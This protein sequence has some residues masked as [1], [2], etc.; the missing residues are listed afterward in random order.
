MKRL[1]LI[2]GSTWLSTVEYYSQINRLA[3]IAVGGSEFPE[4]ILYSVNFGEL[5]RNVAG[6]RMDLNIQLTVDR[7]RDIKAAGAEAVVLCANT[8]HLAAER[9]EA[10]VGLPVIHVA[11]ATAS[12][13]EAAGLNKVGLLGTRFTM[14]GTFFTDCLHDAKIDAL[15]PE[16][17]SD[18]QAIHDPIFQEFGAGIFSAETKATY[19][20]IIDE[21]IQRGAEGIIFGCTEIP[22]LLKPEDVPVPT[23]DTTTIHSEAAV[24]FALGSMP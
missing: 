16:S 24:R 1:G 18:R 13:I 8:L 10:E 11:R 12:A 3:N 15:V 23:F 4:L 7:V 22:L 2:G 20:R 6:G 21:L 14:E 5:S 19:L 17:L 9:I